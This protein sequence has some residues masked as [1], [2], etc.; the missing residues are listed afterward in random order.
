MKNF[1]INTK[2]VWGGNNENCF[3][4]EIFCHPIFCKK[5]LNWLPQF[6]FYIWKKNITN[7]KWELRMIYSNDRILRLV[8]YRKTLHN[9]KLMLK[10]N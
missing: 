3:N 1:T 2:A 7:M 6:S 9:G 5:L 10:R 4:L 8:K